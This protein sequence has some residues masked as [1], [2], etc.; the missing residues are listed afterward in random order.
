MSASLGNTGH[1]AKVEISADVTATP[2]YTEIKQVV[3][4]TAPEDEMG[5]GELTNF[6][7]PGRRREWTPTLLNDAVWGF[8]Y[9]WNQTDPGQL[10]VA[11]L[12][13]TAKLVSSQKLHP[14]VAIRASPHATLLALIP[15]SLSSPVYLL[16]FVTRR[17]VRKFSDIPARTTDVSETAWRLSGDTYSFDELFP[18][19]IDDAPWEPDLAEAD[20]LVHLLC[21]FCI[22][23]APSAAHLE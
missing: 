11:S 15:L 8:D 21:V 5:F 7:S 13:Y 17:V 12:F 6:N 2:T 16:D 14:L 9:Y 22:E 20:I 1:G 19:L 18:I 10:L 3:K 23:R 4:I